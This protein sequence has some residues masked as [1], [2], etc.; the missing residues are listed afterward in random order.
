MGFQK[1]PSLGVLVINPG[2]T[3]LSGFI[4]YTTFSD[5]NNFTK[6]SE[7]AQTSAEK[8]LQY[9]KFFKLYSIEPSI[10]AKIVH[11]LSLFKLQEINCP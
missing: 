1:K 11:S 4:T 5:L 7:L 2:S 9:I 10:F 3:L 6:N 8:K